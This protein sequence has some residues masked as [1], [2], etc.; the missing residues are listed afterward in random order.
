MAQL[1]IIIA[2][3]PFLFMGAGHGALTLRDLKHPRAFVP[4]DPALRQAMQ[5]SSIAL[6]RSINLWRAWL[7]FNLTHSL[8]LVLFGAAFMHVGIF[9]PNAFASSLLLQAVAVLVS[10]IYLVL[11]LNF[12]FSKPAIYSTIG[13][14]CFL[15]AA[16]LAYA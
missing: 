15:V 7:G 14:V 2:A 11:S 4:R 10:A 12:F 13:L 9:E 16:G 3:F 1:L 6:H 8:G 5:Q